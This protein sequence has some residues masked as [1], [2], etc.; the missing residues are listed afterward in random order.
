MFLRSLIRRVSL[1]V[2][3]LVATVSLAGA[4][5]AEGKL[6]FASIVKQPVKVFLDGRLLGEVMTDGI[7]RFPAPNGSHTLRVQTPGGGAAE[8]SVSFTD[9]NVAEANGGRWWC[10]ASGEQGASLMIIVMPTPDC[11]KFV[12][13]ET[14]AVAPAPART[15]ASTEFYYA[16]PLGEV[17]TLW[18]DGRKVGEAMPKTTDAVRVAAGRHSLRFLRSDGREETIEV[19]LAAGD[20]TNAKGRSFWCVTSSFGDALKAERLDPLLLDRDFC[21]KFIGDGDRLPSQDP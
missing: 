8:T 10:V 19:T 2:S 17:V 18:V 12:A 20:L 11:Q 3:V 1:G 15:S 13:A 14:P 6:Y 4:A 5:C 21:Q 16:N 9:G 7:G